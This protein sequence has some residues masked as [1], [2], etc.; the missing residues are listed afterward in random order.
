MSVRQRNPV[1]TGDRTAS[2]L[3][4]HWPTE[5]STGTGKSQC[6]TIQHKV[7]WVPS[8]H[9]P[10]LLHCHHSLGHWEVP[11][12]HEFNFENTKLPYLQWNYKYLPTF[13][14]KG[15]FSFKCDGLV[16]VVSLWV[17]LKWALV[18]CWMFCGAVASQ[19]CGDCGVIASLTLTT[20]EHHSLEEN[21]TRRIVASVTLTLLIIFTISIMSTSWS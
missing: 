11:K 20:A 18:S 8:L 5:G 12:N 1:H 9:G 4:S 2:D 3:V 15:L 21:F 19:C 16:M 13:W 14:S 17:S 10:Q 7:V 6:Q